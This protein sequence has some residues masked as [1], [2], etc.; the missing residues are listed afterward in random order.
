MSTERPLSITILCILTLVGVALTMLSAV[1]PD[2]REV[3]ISRFGPK[4]FVAAIL[5]VV[6]CGVGVIGCW[7]MRRWGV[8][9]I[10]AAALVGFMVKWLIPSPYST[11]SAKSALS[12]LFPIVGF[13]NFKKMS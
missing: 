12:L 2:T 8:Y 9:V 11:W 1:L 7:R 4:F 13:L 10:T 6:V 3:F 5:L